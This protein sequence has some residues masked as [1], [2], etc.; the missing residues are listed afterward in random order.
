M[1]SGLQEALVKNSNFVLVKGV[2]EYLT[3]YCC[4][5]KKGVKVTF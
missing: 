5:T 4:K 3:R 1:E 2:V